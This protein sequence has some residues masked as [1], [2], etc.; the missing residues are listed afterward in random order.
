MAKL[1]LFDLRAC[2]LPVVRALCV[3][4]HG[5]AS[6]GNNATYAFAVYENDRPVAAFV[7][8]PPPPGAA[9][10]VC[11]ESP[12]GVLALSR[13]VAVPHEQR[14]LAHI[15]KPL[16]RNERETPAMPVCSTTRS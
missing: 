7:W 16:R 11:P 13:M 12:G 6:A 15:S 10:S 14:R 1:P 2:D 5:Y 8:Q 9:R 4:H 3:A